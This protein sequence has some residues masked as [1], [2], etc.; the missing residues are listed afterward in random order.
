M[1]PSATTRRATTRPSDHATSSDS[2]HSADAASSARSSVSGA[3]E[4]T[5]ASRT[6]GR[7]SA[8]AIA[9][10][11]WPASAEP[12]GRTA[13]VPEVSRY[14]VPPGRS[15]AIRS[16]APGRRRSRRPGRRRRR[17]WSDP[18]ERG[19]ELLRRRRPGGARP[20]RHG[21]RRAAR[22]P[23]RRRVRARPRTSSATISAARRSPDDR[24]AVEQ[25]PREPRVGGDPGDRAAAVGHRAVVGHCSEAGERRRGRPPSRPRAAGPSGRARPGRGA[26]GGDLE[27][28]RGEVGGRDLGLG[29]AARWA[30][31][32]SDQQR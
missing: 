22:R 27:G 10:H 13:P 5:V 3:A 16:G 1:A 24:G 15:R 25:R 31:S 30:C 4:R 18:V 32:A 19:P 26:P 29:C 8:S 6:P 17:R 23:G 9:S 11:G 14:D 20:D 2:C 21:V 7:R 28:E 12:A